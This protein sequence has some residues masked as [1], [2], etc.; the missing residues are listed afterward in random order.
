[1][2]ALGLALLLAFPLALLVRRTRTGRLLALGI[3]GVV[4]TIPSLALF[5]LLGPVF[6][7]TARCRSWSRWPRT[8]GGAGPASG[9]RAREVPAEVVE[10]ARRDRARPAFRLLARVELPIALPAIVAGLRLATVST[11]ALVTVAAVVGHG[12]LGSAARTRAS[13]PTTRRSS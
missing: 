4:Y 2:A 13:R 8:R 1:M 9:R 3:G 10:A 11:I 6:G 7:F 12:G 5:V